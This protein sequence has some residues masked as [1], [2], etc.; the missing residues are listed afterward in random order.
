[1]ENNLS[2]VSDILASDSFN[3]KMQWDRRGDVDIN[4]DDI[5]PGSSTPNKPLIR[6]GIST[7]PK[8]GRGCQTKP[9]TP[10]TSTGEVLNTTLN[11]NSPEVIPV[12]LVHVLVLT[13]MTTDTEDVYNKNKT[14]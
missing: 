9:D 4:K 12:R 1:M 6:S 7:P 11:L 3:D 14:I 8:A 5:K 2:Y 13:D 10:H